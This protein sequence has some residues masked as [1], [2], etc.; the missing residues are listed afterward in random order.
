MYP[1]LE[2]IQ[3]G[4]KMFEVAW[5][6]YFNYDDGLHAEQPSEEKEAPVIIV[7][8]NEIFIPFHKYY[9]IIKCLLH[10]LIIDIII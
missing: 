2:T 1:D 5:Q 10:V 4:N 9:D 3:P 8:S 7:V 6:L